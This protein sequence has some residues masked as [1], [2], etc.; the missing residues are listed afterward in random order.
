M[1]AMPHPM[2]RRDREL[3][4]AAAF[5]ILAKAGDGVLATWGE[6]GYPYAVPLNHTFADGVLYLHS[7]QTGHKLENLAH[8]DKVSYCV[9]TEHAV[10]PAELST[11]YESAIVFGRAVRVEEP[12]EKRRGLMALLHRFAPGHMAFGLAELEREFEHTALLRIDIHRITGKARPKD[13]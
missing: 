3:D 11:Q 1:T 6:D 5:A 13:E 10:L 12:E 7:A 9:V 4:E 2:R 8:C